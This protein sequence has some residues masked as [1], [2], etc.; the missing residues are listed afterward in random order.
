[1]KKLGATLTPSASEDIPDTPPFSA[2]IAMTRNVPNNNTSSLCTGTDN[3]CISL[4][5]QE[6]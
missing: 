4:K 3:P 5:D 1:M 2:C 6:C